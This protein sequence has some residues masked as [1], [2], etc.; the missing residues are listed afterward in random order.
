LEKVGLEAT[1]A[2]EK[3]GRWEGG[4]EGRSKQG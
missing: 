1:L 3:M 4:K 2:E